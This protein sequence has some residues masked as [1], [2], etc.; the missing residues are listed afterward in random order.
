MA[1]EESI[2]NLKPEALRGQRRGTIAAIPC[3]DPADPR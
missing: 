1:T 2:V 3:E